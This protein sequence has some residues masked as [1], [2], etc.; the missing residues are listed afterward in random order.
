MIRDDTSGLLDQEI[1]VALCAPAVLVHVQTR[2]EFRGTRGGAEKR[3][4]SVC[5]LA[6]LHQLEKPPLSETVGV[7]LV[8]EPGLDRR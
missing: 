8:D 2:L 5:L 3:E 1:D 6:A 4:N 7:E